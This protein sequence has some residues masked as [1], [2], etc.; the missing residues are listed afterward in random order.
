MWLYTV[1][2]C[3]LMW[4][5][6]VVVTGLRTCNKMLNSQTVAIKTLYTYYCCWR[7]VIH[8]LGAT[9]WQWFKLLPVRFWVQPTGQDTFLCLCL[10]GFAPGSLA[11]LQSVHSPMT[12]LML[13]ILMHNSLTL[14][15]PLALCQRLQVDVRNT[16]RFRYDS[17]P[18][19]V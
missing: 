17:L 13:T 3:C 14:V 19:R 9:G 8:V 12:P 7:Y 15:Q 4:D 18:K 10:C 2:V 11:S 1:P 5:L 16:S 6:V